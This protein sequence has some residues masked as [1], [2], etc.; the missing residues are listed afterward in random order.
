MNVCYPA[1]IH[2]VDAV[3]VTVP[4]L[5]LSLKYMTATW[6]EIAP[7]LLSWTCNYFSSK[8]QLTKAVTFGGCSFISE[9]KN[10]K[11]SSSSS[12]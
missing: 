8:F 4:L 5:E 2:P 12:W 10:Y 1:E 3:K 7:S 9:V 11:K 6:L